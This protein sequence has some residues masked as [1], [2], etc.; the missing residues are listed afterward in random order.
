MNNNP[1][2][3]SYVDW[4]RDLNKPKKFKE[5]DRGWKA[6]TYSMPMPVNCSS[7][8]CCDDDWQIDCEIDDN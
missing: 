6:T 4:V 3:V 2:P 1:T 7:S 8:C 5:I